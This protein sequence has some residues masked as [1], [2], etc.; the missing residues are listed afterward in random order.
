MEK[1]KF[2]NNIVEEINN[3]LKS[4]KGFKYLLLKYRSLPLVSAISEYKN[5]HIAVTI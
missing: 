3:F 4:K 1:E 5:T 2:A